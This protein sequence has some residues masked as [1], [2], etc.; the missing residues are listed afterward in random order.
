MDLTRIA[1]PTAKDH[2]RIEKYQKAREFLLV[3]E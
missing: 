2:A 1:A 3:T